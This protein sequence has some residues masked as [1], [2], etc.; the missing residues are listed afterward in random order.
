M[1]SFIPIVG[2]S[3]SLVCP[4][5]FSTLHFKCEGLAIRNIT[6]EICSSII[7]L[8]TLQLVNEAIQ[9]NDDSNEKN[10]SPQPVQY[11]SEI[12]A[13]VSCTNGSTLGVDQVFATINETKKNHSLPK[14]MSPEVTA[15]VADERIMTIHQLCWPVFFITYILEFFLFGK[16]KPYCVIG[17]VRVYRRKIPFLGYRFIPAPKTTTSYSLLAAIVFFFYVCASFSVYRCEDSRLHQFLQFLK[18]MTSIL[19]F[20][21][22][23]LAYYDP[24]FLLP[25]YMT[26]DENGGSQILDAAAA[27]RKPKDQNTS[28][29]GQLSSIDKNTRE[30][31]WVMVNGVPILRKWCSVC[32]FYRPARAAHCYQCGMCVSAHDHHCVVTGSCVGS[33]NIVYFTGFVTQGTITAGLAGLVTFQCLYYHRSMFSTHLYWFLLLCNVLFCWILTTCATFLTISLWMNLFTATTTREKLTGVY[34]SKQNPFRHRWY[35]N[36]YYYLVK[37]RKS[38]TIFRD[39]IM[40]A[41]VPVDPDDRRFVV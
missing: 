11:S 8:E 21:L 15:A 41:V 22:F 24:G 10:A 23:R 18:I 4:S 40:S 17:R 35:Q 7:S 14:K 6:C 39:E 37:H 30:E 16:S 33:R 31:K 27:N 34:Q 19:Y 32:G 1:P 5:C 20:N 25:A 2:Y 3:Y 12:E 13:N 28:V 26:G 29:I 36:L 38:P 9:Q